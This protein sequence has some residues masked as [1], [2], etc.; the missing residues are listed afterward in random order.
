MDKL[1]RLNDQAINSNVF[2]S[3][4]QHKEVRAALSRGGSLFVWLGYHDKTPLAENLRVVRRTASEIS[5]LTSLTSNIVAHIC[6]RH[7]AVTGE[8]LY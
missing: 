5:N 4:H 1:R 7:F 6:A 2:V 8:R 3:L